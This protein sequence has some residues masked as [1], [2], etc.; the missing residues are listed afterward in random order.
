[1]CGRQPTKNLK[2][3][4]GCLPQILLGPFLNTFTHPFFI[5]KYSLIS[6]CFELFYYQYTLYKSLEVSLSLINIPKN[7]INS[8]VADSTIFGIS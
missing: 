2:L 1:M 6:L 3:F 7:S 4:K 8:E 5:L